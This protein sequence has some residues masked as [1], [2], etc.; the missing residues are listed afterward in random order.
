MRLIS[1][2]SREYKNRKYLKFWVI[3]PN[4]IVEKLGWKAGDNLEVDVKNG[5]LVIEKEGNN[6]ITPKVKREK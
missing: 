6:H 3:V 4:T 5:K 2:I 1:Q